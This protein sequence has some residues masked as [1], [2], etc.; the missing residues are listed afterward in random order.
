M[1]LKSASFSSILPGPIQD[2][3]LGSILGLREVNIQGLRSRFYLW[4][5]DSI[6]EKVD[7][8]ATNYLNY[9]VVSS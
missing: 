4:F 9:N 7:Q 6:V 8:R 3:G 2:L 5:Q 1:R